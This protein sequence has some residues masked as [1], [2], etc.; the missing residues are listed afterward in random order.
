MV[1]IEHHI[2]CLKPKICRLNWQDNSPD[3]STE[4]IQ[5]KLLYY[6][7]YIYNRGQ[8]P[9]LEYRKPLTRVAFGHQI[10]LR[11]SQMRI[12]VLFTIKH[13]FLD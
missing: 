4:S 8:L 3:E 9:I 12:A 11:S 13:F 1:K 6:D 5:V 10:K 7:V 2:S